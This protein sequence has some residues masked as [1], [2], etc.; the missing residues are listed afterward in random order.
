MS[1]LAIKYKILFRFIQSTIAAEWEKTQTI[2]KSSAMRKDRSPE[3]VM[4]P[5][6]W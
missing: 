6:D 4:L 1:I 5:E 2:E 3:S